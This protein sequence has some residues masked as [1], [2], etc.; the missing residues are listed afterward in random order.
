MT[1]SFQE[2][3]PWLSYL[4]VPGAF[5]CRKFIWLDEVR[6]HPEKAG[7]DNAK[8]SLPATGFLP[9]A[10]KKH[11]SQQCHHDG[12]DAS[13]NEHLEQRGIIGQDIKR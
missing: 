8:V 10:C 7:T 12:Q 2:T 5:S 13:G 11:L 9:P 4:G 6:E 3:F 1:G